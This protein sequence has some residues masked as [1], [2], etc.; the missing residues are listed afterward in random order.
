MIP[1]L[2]F[3]LFSLTANAEETGYVKES[4]WLLVPNISSDSEIGSSTGFM[5]AHLKK[6]AYVG[7][8][9]S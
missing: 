2:P 5:G 6:F 4:P 1:A 9:N 7:F 3:M 8:D